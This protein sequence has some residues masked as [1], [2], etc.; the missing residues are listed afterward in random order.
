MVERRV[1]MAKGQ[2]KNQTP[3]QGRNV[4]FG[5]VVSDAFRAFAIATH[6]YAVA[7]APAGKGLK[8]G[9]DAIGIPTPYSERGWC[10][11]FSSSMPE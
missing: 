5:R 3:P 11:W 9:S 1:A 8:Q 10:R 7:T 2:E 6:R 4:A